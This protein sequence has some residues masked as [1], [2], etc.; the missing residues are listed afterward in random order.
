MIL[1]GAKRADHRY[2][3]LPVSLDTVHATCQSFSLTFV[4]EQYHQSHQDLLTAKQKHS[5]ASRDDTHLPRLL[6]TYKTALVGKNCAKNDY[7][8]K[9]GVSRRVGEVWSDTTEVGREDLGD[10]EEE[11]EQANR[12][13]PGLA[14][15]QDE[16]QTQYVSSVKRVNDLLSYTST[17]YSGFYTAQARYSDG[18]TE[19]HTKVDG[20]ID[21]DLFADWNA[22]SES[23]DHLAD[24]GLTSGGGLGGSKATFIP[25]PGH[26][27][28]PRMTLGET[29]SLGFDEPG[30]SAGL[31]PPDSSLARGKGEEIIGLQN[32]L[33][34]SRE[35]KNKLEAACF[36]WNKEVG[37]QRKVIR[38]CEANR[39]LGDPDEVVEV[40][41]AVEWERV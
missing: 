35:M 19:A 1:E 18:I 31:G 41:G 38:S 3:H 32:R 2:L 25:C 7:L 10:V 29:D 11:E 13:G 27:E 39:G 22:R 16:V 23:P 37:R 4:I 26:P 14:R 9:V 15:C 12:F 34:K 21:A 33:A 40:S 6:K 20:M 17:I 30:G 28:E 36:G 8:L 5:K 24:H